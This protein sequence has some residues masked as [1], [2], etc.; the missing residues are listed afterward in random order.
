MAHS[1]VLPSPKPGLHL[2][3]LIRTQQGHLLLW[4][5]HSVTW[6]MTLKSEMAQLQAHLPTTS[7]SLPTPNRGFLLLLQALFPLQILSSQLSQSAAAGSNPASLLSLSSLSYL[8]PAVVQPSLVH[9]TRWVPGSTGVGRGRRIC[10]LSWYFYLPRAG[11]VCSEW[12]KNYLNM[13]KTQNLEI[14]RFSFRNRTSLNIWGGA[15]ERGW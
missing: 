5:T 15:G 9:G 4:H 14:I 8:T 1:L 3:D 13:I 2:T 12:L 10:L 6:V 11:R 7:M